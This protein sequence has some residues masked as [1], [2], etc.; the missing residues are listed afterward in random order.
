MDNISIQA[1]EPAESF[2]WVPIFRSRFRYIATLEVHVRF[3]P[4][5]DVLCHY[6]SAVNLGDTPILHFYFFLCGS[7][8]KS[9]PG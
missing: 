7:Y 5:T 2:C 6:A 1:V 9:S 8:V 3:L 4:V